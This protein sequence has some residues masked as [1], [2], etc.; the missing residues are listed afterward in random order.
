M[1]IRDRSCT[2]Q[3]IVCLDADDKIP[4]NYL[5]ENYVN[6]I[7]SNVDVSYTDVRCFGI[8]SQILYWPE[9]SV[10]NLRIGNYI[11][12]A[13]MFNKN[14]WKL[15]G[16]YDELMTDGLEDYDLWLRF[17]KVGAKFKKTSKT[18]LWWRKLSNSMTTTLHLKLNEV[19]HYLKTKHG[20]WYRGQT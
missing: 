2:G 17:A 18:F 13:A 19:H 15:V 1:C 7:H 8:S 10:D 5:E 6:I 20:D 4:S 3:Y 16:G 11:H 14:I 9:F 12:C